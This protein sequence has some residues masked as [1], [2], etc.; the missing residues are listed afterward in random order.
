MVR[1]IG[2][3]R[4]PFTEKVQAPRQ[5]AAAPGVSARIELLATFEHALADLDTFDRVWIVFWFDRVPERPAPSKVLP[6]RS[7]TKRGVFATRSPHRPN[8]IGMTPARLV[9]IEGAVLHVE[10]IDLLDGTPV[11]DLKPYIPYCDAFPDASSGWLTASDPQP[12]WHVTFSD[13]A[14]AQL[15]WIGEHGNPDLRARIGAA[16]ALGPE[17]HPYRRIK[18]DDAGASILAVKD[19]RV[20]FRVDDRTIV[21]DRIRT[22][23]RPRELAR[24]EDPTRALH[25]VFAARFG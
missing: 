16:L 22:G 6:P 19:W 23:Y 13:E 8:P 2:F 10:D 4:S 1:P 11:L 9:R 17:P 18:R 20:L 14:D 5:G 24:P 7:S 25:S 21:V 12:A 3:V 15:A